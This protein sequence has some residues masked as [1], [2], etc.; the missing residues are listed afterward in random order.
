MLQEFL[1]GVGDV[2]VGDG[3]RLDRR[4]QAF[5]RG[6]VSPPRIDGTELIVE[7]G[8]GRMD[9]RFPS[10]PFRTA[11]DHLRAQVRFDRQCLSFQCRLQSTLIRYL[12]NARLRCLA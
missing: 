3:N 5:Q 10:V 7:D 8:A 11:T 9:M 6:E 12:W 2:I 1:V 4:P